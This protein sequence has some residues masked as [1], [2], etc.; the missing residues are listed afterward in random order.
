MLMF[1]AEG[2]GLYRMEGNINIE[3]LE[4]FFSDFIK[5]AQTSWAHYGCRIG[6]DNNLETSQEA[7]E[8]ADQY[9]ELH[10]ESCQIS[11]RK[12]AKLACQ[13]LGMSLLESAL[14]LSASQI[15]LTKLHQT[16]QVLDSLDH[17]G[18]DSKTVLEDHNHILRKNNRPCPKFL[19][20]RT[21]QKSN[22]TVKKGLPAS[23]YHCHFLSQLSDPDREGLE[24]PPMDL[25]NSEQ[26]T[27][28]R[29]VMKMVNRCE[30]GIEPQ[31]S[32]QPTYPVCSA[33]VCHYCL[34]AN[35]ADTKTQLRHWPDTAAIFLLIG[36]WNF[37]LDYHFP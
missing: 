32:S 22:Q 31:Q 5:E 11:S 20:R 15:D 13:R 34:P 29:R 3:A 26:Q 33:F 37:H 1:T 8:R 10:K 17:E 12:H 7:K 18:M 23:L 19:H 6:K 27:Q 4:A 9:S 2:K 21:G 16:R 36:N 14:P 28:I 24:I 35:G 25:P 30:W